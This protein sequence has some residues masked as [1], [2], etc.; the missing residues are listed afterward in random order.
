MTSTE[1]CVDICVYYEMYI[2]NAPINNLS[3]F[4]YEHFVCN[5]LNDVPPGG[6]NK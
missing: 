2:Q 1:F 3:D 4:F 5:K 6:I